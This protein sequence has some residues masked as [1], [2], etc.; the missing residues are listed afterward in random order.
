LTLVLLD[1][2]G[3]ILDHSWFFKVIFLPWEDLR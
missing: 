1:G 3:K 2:R